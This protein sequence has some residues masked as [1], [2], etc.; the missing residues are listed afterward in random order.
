HLSADA[1]ACWVPAR[2]RFASSAGMTAEFNFP[3]ELDFPQMIALRPRQ[4]L[5]ADL[6]ERRAA[7]GVL[8][9]GPGEARIEIVAAV[10]VDG[11]GLDLSADALGRIHV[12]GPDR[13][14]EAIGRIVHQADG[15]R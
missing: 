1:V 13:S 2:A 15:F 11:A 10:H 8:H 6:A 4:R 12:A 5:I 7:A 9:T 14:R 3:A